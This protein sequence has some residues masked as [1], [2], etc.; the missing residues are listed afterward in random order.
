MSDRL[1]LERSTYTYYETGKTQPTCETLMELAR[2]YGV[3]VD[4]LLGAKQSSVS[5]EKRFFLHFIDLT[6]EE[7]TALL[8]QLEDLAEK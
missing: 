6:E 2:L 7:Q 8:R 3:S 4:F 5:I 1:H